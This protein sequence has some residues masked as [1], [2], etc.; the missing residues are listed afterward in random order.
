MNIMPDE[1]NAIKFFQ[2]IGL[3]TQTSDRRCPKCF[4]K[5]WVWKKDNQRTDN[6]RFECKKCTKKWLLRDNTIF[7]NLRIEFSKIY[8]ILLY[9]FIQRRSMNY[10]SEKYNISKDTVSKLYNYCGTICENVIEMYYNC[11]SLGK[12]LTL[13]EIKKPEIEI[14]ETDDMIYY[15]ENNNLYYHQSPGVEI[16]EC[17]LGHFNKDENVFMKQQWV[18]GIVDRSTKDFKV[19]LT[20]DRSQETIDD[21]VTTNVHNNYLIKTR[22]YTDCWAG[23]T[24]ISNLGYS[25]HKVNHSIGFGI[26]TYTTNH[27]ENL[28]SRIKGTGL[29]EEGF[30]SS[31]YSAVYRQLKIAEYL[32]LFNNFDDILNQIVKFQITID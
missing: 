32:V 22:I 19:F 17:L 30:S 3:L 16:D 10:I 1:I 31:D 15:D 20:N 2:E 7:T 21:I 24:N 12:E 23:Y 8:C 5:D 13:E 18:I 14:V 4:E 25:H 26:G 28:W 6:G 11:C 29:F 9:G 27:V